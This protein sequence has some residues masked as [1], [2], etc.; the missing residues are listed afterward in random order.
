MKKGDRIIERFIVVVDSLIERHGK[1][2][3]FCANDSIWSEN[4]HYSNL[5]FYSPAIRSKILRNEQFYPTP[6]DDIYLALMKT[7]V[8]ITGY[9]PPPWFHKNRT[10][11]LLL[12]SKM[13]TV[14][15]MKKEALMMLL[16]KCTSYNAQKVLIDAKDI[17]LM[18]EYEILKK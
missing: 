4:K 16:E 15:D 6:Y 5:T 1:G 3:L 14:D 9:T 12:C 2:E 11:L 10:W 18:D 13:K 17:L 8:E 7:Y